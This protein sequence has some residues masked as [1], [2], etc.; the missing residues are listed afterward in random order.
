MELYLRQ[1]KYNFNA[2]HHLHAL[3]PNEAFVF[4]ICTDKEIWNI[5]CSKDSFSYEQ[6]SNLE[7]IDSFI[8]TTK[9]TAI[10]LLNGDTRLS[11]LKKQNEIVYE[12]SFRHFLLLE[13]VIWLCREYDELDSA[14]SF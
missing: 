2:R 11:Q 14:A 13:S 6:S 1:L 5:S 4:C 7:N 9:S 12:G 8:S 10:R 3:L